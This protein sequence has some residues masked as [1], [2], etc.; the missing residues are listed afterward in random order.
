M[1]ENLW[2]S[3]TLAAEPMAGR[4]AASSLCGSCR[5]PLSLA[6][7]LFWGDVNFLFLYIAIKTGENLQ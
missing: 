7:P 4:A 3:E 5:P 2:Q 1:S 6:R